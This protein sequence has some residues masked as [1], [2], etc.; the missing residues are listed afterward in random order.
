MSLDLFIPFVIKTAILLA[1]QGPTIL[2]VA[3]SSLI[4]AMLLQPLP[5][6]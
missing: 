3:V 4:V 2:L 5:A 6:D 1:T